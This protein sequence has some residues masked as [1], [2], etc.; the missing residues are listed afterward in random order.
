MPKN[1]KLSIGRNWIKF[2]LK[3]FLGCNVFETANNTE[4]NGQFSIFIKSLLTKRQGNNACGGNGEMKTASGIVQ[5][6]D[7]IDDEFA[8]FGVSLWITSIENKILSEKK[9]CWMSVLFK[10]PEN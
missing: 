4:K 6:L 7:G 5:M 9:T 3:N 2:L 1:Q 8:R 10:V